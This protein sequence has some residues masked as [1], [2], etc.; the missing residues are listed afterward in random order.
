MTYDEA[1]AAARKGDYVT[2]PGRGKG[3]TVGIF[4]GIVGG[5]LWNFNPHTGSEYSY[6]PLPGD[7]ERLDWRIAKNKR[8]A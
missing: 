4:P 7:R 2:H 3:W 8:D 1:M 6:N 5:S